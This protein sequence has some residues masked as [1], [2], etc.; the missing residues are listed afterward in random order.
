MFSAAKRI[1]IVL[2]HYRCR[3]AGATR[4]TQT[5]WQ[6]MARNGQTQ[7][8]RLRLKRV[9]GSRCE[10][11]P[12]LESGRSSKICKD[13]QRS[14]GSMVRCE[15]NDGEWRDMVRNGEGLK[16]ELLRWCRIQFQLLAVTAGAFAFIFSEVLKS[17]SRT[18]LPEG[19]SRPEKVQDSLREGK[20]CWKAKREPKMWSPSIF[21]QS[22]WRLR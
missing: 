21:S 20:I 19:Y 17:W 11:L 12:H 10:A 9:T 15:V 4:K 18:V 22:P 16:D 5:R 1:I 8:P 7:S 2:Q 6:D 3:V 13:L 14:K